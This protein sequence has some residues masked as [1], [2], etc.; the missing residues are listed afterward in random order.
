MFPVA[1]AQP[2]LPLGVL[3]TVGGPVEAVNRDQNNH[4]EV[5]QTIRRA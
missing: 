1:S 3:Y 5:L 2:G 4:K